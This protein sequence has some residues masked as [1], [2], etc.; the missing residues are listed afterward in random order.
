MNIVVH[1]KFKRFDW[2]L[3]LHI[4]LFAP[5]GV[6]SLKAQWEFPDAQSSHIR[7]IWACQRS[8]PV[9]WVERSNDREACQ[10][11]SWTPSGPI[12]VRASGRENPIRQLK[13]LRSATNSPAYPNH[14]R[15]S[16]ST[17]PIT[18]YVSDDLTFPLENW[19]ER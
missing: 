3:A 16:L 18:Q 8:N 5:S 4:P 13:T 15:I 10:M 14:T 7:L 2:A 9:V 12:S 6:S 17:Q 1:R 11:T 19:E